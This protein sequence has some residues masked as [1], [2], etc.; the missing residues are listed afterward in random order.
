MKNNITTLFRY[1]NKNKEYL[2]DKYVYFREYIEIIYNKFNE[3]TCEQT[4]SINSIF[5]LST[6]IP[7]TSIKHT[8][9]TVL[10]KYSGKK[11][12]ELHPLMN[13]LV[14]DSQEQ[15]FAIHIY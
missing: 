13:M 9:D 12:I 8:Y 2:Y 11:T 4:Y 14:L 1:I 7:I 10:N 3:K 15:F 5:G 6:Y